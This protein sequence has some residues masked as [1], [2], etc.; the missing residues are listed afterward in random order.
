M[1]WPRGPAKREA[2]PAPPAAHRVLSRADTEQAKEF[3]Y[4]KQKRRH[5]KI[6]EKNGVGRGLAGRLLESFPHRERAGPGQ[7]RA[8]TRSVITLRLSRCRADSRSFNPIPDSHHKGKNKESGPLRAT[9][10]GVRRGAAW[11]GAALVHWRTRKGLASVWLVHSR[12]SLF[13]PI[14]FSAVSPFIF[15]CPFS[16]FNVFIFF[17]ADGG[18]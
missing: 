9:P 16:F 11:R 12:V 10:A 5:R 14:L 4:E 7:G 3:I 2:Y 18:K 8:G 6:A 15:Q 17:L 1:H 13:H